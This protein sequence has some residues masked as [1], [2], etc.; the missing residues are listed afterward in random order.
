MSIRLFEDDW[1]R[2][3]VDWRNDYEP[4]QL[5][6][7]G[8]PREMPGSPY[9]TCPTEWFLDDSEDWLGMSEELESLPDGRYLVRFWT[10]R[11]NQVLA[12]WHVAGGGLDIEAIPT[13]QETLFDLSTAEGA[14]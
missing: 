12:L 10:D 9:Y 14:A 8:C 3:T 7:P 4:Y 5:E 2:L 1:H 11:T 13:Q 6:H